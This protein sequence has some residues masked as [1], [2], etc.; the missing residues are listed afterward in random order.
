M[1]KLRRLALEREASV[2]DIVNEALDSFLNFHETGVNL[3]DVMRGI[4]RSLARTEY[5]ITNVDPHNYAVSVK[6][7]IR[8]VYRPELKY[9][10]AMARDGGA[11]VVKISASLRTHDISAL[12]RFS[13]FTELWVTLEARYIKP[14]EQ[15]G[16]VSDAG[17][18]E[19]KSRLSAYERLSRAQDYG[20]ALSGYITIFDELFK[21]FYSR[22]AGGAAEIEK[23]FRDR[24]MSGDLQI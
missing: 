23:L 12:R 9:L 14:R 15:V 18:F 6:S 7:P 10:I 19:R 3:L 13:A 5:F 16:Y 11:S 2:H 1:L 8:Y 22:P 20:A 24:A 17:Y 21:R 4:E